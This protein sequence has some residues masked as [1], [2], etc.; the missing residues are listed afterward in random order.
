VK[1]LDYSVHPVSHKSR[2]KLLKW[3]RS[4]LLLMFLLIG[5]ELLK[6]IYFI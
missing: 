4:C 6:L 3:I 1:T 5:L 2:F